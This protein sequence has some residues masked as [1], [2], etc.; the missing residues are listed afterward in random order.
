MTGVGHKGVE[1][2][3]SKRIKGNKEN[4]NP[5]RIFVEVNKHTVTMDIPLCIGNP[6]AGVEGECSV[7]TESAEE[8]D[9]RAAEPF[10]TAT[11][12]AEKFRPPPDVTGSSVHIE[13]SLSAY[14]AP[15]SPVIDETVVVTGFP[16]KTATPSSPTTRAATTTTFVQHTAGKSSSHALTSSSTGHSPIVTTVDTI[17]IISNATQ[18][19][20]QTVTNLKTTTIIGTIGAIYPPSNPNPGS[21]GSGSS[22]TANQAHLLTVGG[23]T[24]LAGAVFTAVIFLLVRYVM[25]V[26]QRRRWASEDAQLQASSQVEK[27]SGGGVGG[28]QGV[29]QGLGVMNAAHQ[30]WGQAGAHHAGF[31]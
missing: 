16:R 6:A 20:F 29:A 11:E 13:P 5:H 14:V 24:V 19:T 10:S 25:K 26:R 18:T 8:H 30:A 17:T 12:A 4:N 22:T 15:L 9:N 31:V 2:T 7:T 21:F 3:I 28:D 27:G 23:S 1:T